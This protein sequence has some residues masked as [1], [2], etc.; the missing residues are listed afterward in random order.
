RDALMQD[1]V[2][3]YVELNK[4]NQEIDLLNTELANNLKVEKIE[5]ERVQAG[6]D[7]P[8]EQNRAKLAT[9]RVRMRMAEARGSADVMRTQLAHLSGLSAEEL[10]IEPNP[11]PGL[12][13]KKQDGDPHAKGIQGIPGMKV[14][15]P[16]VL[17]QRFARDGRFKPVPSAVDIPGGYALLAN[18]NNYI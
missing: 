12:P 10:G 11:S 13:E 14:A 15:D 16:P 6:V 8:I 2:L 17:A 9:A 3:T 18:F 5:Q 7:R 1:T 4:W